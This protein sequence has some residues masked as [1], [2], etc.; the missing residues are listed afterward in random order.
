MMLVWEDEAEDALWLARGTP[1]AWLEQG[2][3]IAVTNSPTFYGRLDYAITSDVANGRID[4][5]VT[6]P[7]RNPTKAVYLRLRHPTK[8]AIE[9]VTVNG[10]EWKDFD[11]KRE[12]VKLH[13]IAKTPIAVSVFYRSK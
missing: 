7:S 8:A 12:V 5:T 6:P 3:R 2:Q 1:R 10:E 4:A 9:R 11:A 13:D